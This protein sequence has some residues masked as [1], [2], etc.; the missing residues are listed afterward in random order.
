MIFEKG[1]ICF[2]VSEHVYCI[3][4]L[5]RYNER[6]SH[7]FS[8]TIMP[9]DPYSLCPGGRNKKIR[10]C[11]PNMLKEIEQVERLLESEQTSAC[12]AYIES[13]EKTHPNCACLTTAK[14]SV[15][16][17]ENRW[18]EA[19]LVAERFHAQEPDN[20]AAAA[21][22]ALALTVT[23]NPKLAL[24]TLVDAF[25]RT[26]ADTVHSAL[27]HATMQV[28]TCL[29]I[30]DLILPAIAIGHVLKEI[31]ST[32]EP[33]NML[34]FRA[35]S[36]SNIPLLLRDWAFDFNCPDNFPGKATFDEAAVLVRLMRWK[37]ALAQLEPLTQ[38]AD[39]WSGIWRNI[40]AIRFWLL[41]EEGGCEALKR[42]ASL[43]NTLLE[44][45][46]DA[47]ATRL[48]FVP[49]ALGDQTEMLAVEYVITDT[50]KALEKLLS[51]PLMYSTDIP[52]Q[53]MSPP[54][55]GGFLIID[56]PLPGAET[57]LTLENAA[58]QQ[59]I[60]VLF[61][62]E[63][64]RESRLFVQALLAYEQEMIE[65][66]LRGI[67]G[68]LIQIP[69]NILKR[70]PVSKTRVLTQCRYCP[71]PERYSDSARETLKKLFDSYSTTVFVESWLTLPLGL[72]DGKT[73]SE[74]AKESKYMVPLLAAIQTIEAWMADGIGDA[75]PDLR[76]RLGLPTQDT[77]TITTSS[78]EDPTAVLDAY[79]VWRWHRFDMSKLSTEVLFSG[80]Q[81]V[82]S[83]QVLRTAARF[84][85]ELLNR[86]IDSMPFPARIMAFETLIADSQANEDVEK[87]LL[88]VER[89]KNESA[90]QDI[91]D[92][93][94]YLH[95][96]S[97]RLMQKN[98]QAA[99]EVLQHLVTHHGND[100]SVM[101]ALH[102]LFVRLGVV[103]PDGT[104][105]AAM[106]RTQQKQ[107]QEE[108]K[109]WTPDGDASAGSAASSKLWVPD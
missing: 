56:R 102:E 16:R 73:P 93:A 55:R 62:K 80:L 86:P 69:G 48:L 13:L 47:E 6:S 77:I 46:A 7:C 18:Q 44:D 27:L 84:A 12:L 14:L 9:F 91:S 83:M 25:E 103:N 10:F 43:P 50:E 32:S 3:L 35:T 60:V 54:P 105:S 109:I 15:Y 23:G 31:P 99:H 95:E 107:R 65:A 53:S 59:A 72:L 30:G 79:P 98:S 101:E 33:A 75:V 17:S 4:C 76:S 71:P 1:A 21:E 41:D 61:G 19:L 68:D 20:P 58:S 97:L 24:S 38:Y 100:E 39:S 29:L 5:F 8:T 74:A 11:C 85:E 36:E 22:Y 45:A 49:D 2:Q 94:W 28:A 78:D 34:L 106:I 88:W 96:L 90:V 40:A 87:A 52:L 89:A 26:Q 81:I 42:Y 64:D 82:F 104:P 70:H 57:P 66:K 37:Q 51:D 108:Q 92:A 67:L 63:T